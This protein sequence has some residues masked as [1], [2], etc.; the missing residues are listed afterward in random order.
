MKDDIVYL[1]VLVGIHDLAL[2]IHV[3][4]SRFEFDCEIERKVGRRRTFSVLEAEWK[5]TGPSDGI[6][7]Y[8]D[9][10]LY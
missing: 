9:P 8:I 6:V 10:R 2:V 7:T 4:F 5:H 1:L 3:C